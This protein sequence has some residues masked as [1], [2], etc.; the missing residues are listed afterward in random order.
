VPARRNTVYGIRD[1][2]IDH[3]PEDIAPLVERKADQNPL[4]FLEMFPE[5][6][7]DTPVTPHVEAAE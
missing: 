5:P 6:A 1:V 3:D 4:A 2:Y 7:V